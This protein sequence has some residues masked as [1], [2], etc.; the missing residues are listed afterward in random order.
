MTVRVLAVWTRQPLVVDALTSRERERLAALPQRVRRQWL[1]S[2]HA[3]R[4]LLGVLGL[5]LDTTRY[6]FPHRRLSLT[7][8]EGAAV[9]AGAVRDTRQLAGVGVDL[10]TDREARVDTTRFFLDER[11]RSWLASLPDTARATEQLRLWTV[12]EA[13]FK[14][15]PDNRHTVLRDYTTLDAAAHRGRARTRQHREAVFGYASTRLRDAQ[16]S[17]AAAFHGETRTPQSIAPGRETPVPSVI[18][19]DEV[20]DRISSTLSIP[21]E[22][23]TPQ[24]TLRELAADSFL[25]VE[26]AVDLQEEFD[27]IFT[28]NELRE[29][30]TLGELAGLVGAKV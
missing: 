25:L 14:A 17:I 29:I 3:L 15:D 9:A 16:L 24:T 22:K 30:T 6:A 4:L 23:L 2:R 27:T 12:K 13:L 7:H 20:A 10:E 11:E 26:M 1:I 5:P 19:F 18:T 21:V 28:Q 8:I